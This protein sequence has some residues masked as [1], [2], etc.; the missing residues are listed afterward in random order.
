[1]IQDAPNREGAVLF[2]EY[3]LQP[4]GGLKILKRMGQP[5]LIPCRVPTEEM[6]NILPPSLRKLVE[7]GN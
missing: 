1:L 2:L 4:E 5:P 7:V 6:K 3:L